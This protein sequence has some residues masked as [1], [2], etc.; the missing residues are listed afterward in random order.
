VDLHDVNWRK[1]SQ[2]NAE[3]GKAPILEANLRSN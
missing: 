3:R 1:T 2:L